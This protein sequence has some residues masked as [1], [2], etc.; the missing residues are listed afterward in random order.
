MSCSCAIKQPLNY[1]FWSTQSVFTHVINDHISQPKQKK[2]IA[3]E[4][5]SISGGLVGDT[6]TATVSLFKDTN[7]APVTSREHQFCYFKNSVK[8]VF[9]VPVKRGVSRWSKFV[10]DRWSR[11]MI[12]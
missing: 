11:A 6:K 2:T 10:L 8:A 9:P 3:L 1:F 5:S 4:L 12:K 7:I